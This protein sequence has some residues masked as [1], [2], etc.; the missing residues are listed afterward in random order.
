MSNIIPIYFEGHPMRFSDDGWF[1]A[2]TAADK[3][4]KRQMISCDYRRLTR[5]F[6]LLSVDTGKSRM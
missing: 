2:T 6:R 5:T 3:F 4:D 1:D